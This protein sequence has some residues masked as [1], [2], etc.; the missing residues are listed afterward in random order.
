MSCHVGNAT[1]GKVVTHPMFAAGHPPLPPIEVASFSKNE[2]QHWR[3]PRD[4]PFLAILREVAELKETD[5]M[6][7]SQAVE[8]DF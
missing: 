7:R 4:V 2:P 8:A 1:Q 6:L 5:M 3:D